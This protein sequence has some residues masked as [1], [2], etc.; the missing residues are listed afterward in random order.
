MIGRERGTKRWLAWAY[1]LISDVGIERR[2]VNIE[3][4][5]GFERD[6]DLTKFVY[7]SSDGNAANIRFVIDLVKQ[8][9]DADLLAQVGVDAA[10]IGAIVDALADIGVTQDLETLDAVRQGIALMQRDQNRG[11]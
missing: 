10:E 4:Y 11:D 5:D 6:G 2:K 1:A 7:Q 3:A 8:I 9:K